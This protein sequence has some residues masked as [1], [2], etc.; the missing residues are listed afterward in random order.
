MG[1]ISSYDEGDEMDL[2]LKGRRA[3]VLGASRGIGR[4]IAAALAA[5]GAALA[6]ASRN[7]DALTTLAADLSARHGVPAYA[8]VADVADQARMDVLAEE[9]MLRLGGVDILVLNHGGPPV[10]PAVELSLEALQEQ[11]TRM[12]VAPIRLAMRLLPGMRDRRWGRI[13]TIGSSGMIQPLPNMVLS[14]T[15]RGAI[16]GWNKTLANEVAAEGV[17][18]NI[19][20]PGAI[21]TE[22]LRETAGF[23]ANRTGT[24]IEEVLAKRAATIPAGRLGRPEEI[25]A[26]AAFLASDRAAYVTGSIVRVDGGLIRCV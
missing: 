19:L 9:A 11:F 21:E 22:R 18:C 24:S 26:V 23:E 17:T 5:E 13:L 3:L 4:A 16:V 15:L 8:I 2:G 10:G 6:L 25:A 14:N 7:R 12:V 20:A 1:T